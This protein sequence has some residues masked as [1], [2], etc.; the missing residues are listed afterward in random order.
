MKVEK[1]KKKKKKKIEW[2]KQNLISFSSDGSGHHDKY[3][4]E[5]P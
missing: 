2:Y 5:I 3:S 4:Y 1:K